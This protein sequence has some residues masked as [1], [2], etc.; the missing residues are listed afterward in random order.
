MNNSTSSRAGVA[1]ALLA[2]VALIPALASATTNSV[3]AQTASEVVKYGDL[4][5]T[6]RSDAKELSHRIHVAAQRVCSIN[7]STTAQHVCYQN[8]VTAAVRQIKVSQRAASSSTL[9]TPLL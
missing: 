1:V 7:E 3:P 4:D 9:S 5:L 8:A 6:Q 2:A